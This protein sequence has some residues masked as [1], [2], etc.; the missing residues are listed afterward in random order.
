MLIF[1]GGTGIRQGRILA[2]AGSGWS[3]ETTFAVTANKPEPA[4]TPE[5]GAVILVV[6]GIACLVVLRRRAVF[7]SMSK[8]LV[9]H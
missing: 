7:N 1:S 8:P 2:F 3:S 4:E 6:L 5:P 9:R